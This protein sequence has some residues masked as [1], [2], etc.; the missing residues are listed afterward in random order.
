MRR[1][2]LIWA[3]ILFT[4]A[5]KNKEHLLIEP[6]KGRVISSLDKIPISNVKIYVE[7]NAFNAF[8]TINTKNDGRFFIDQLSVN[9]YKDMHLQ[10][11]LSYNLFIEKDGYKKMVID[12]R[13]YRKQSAPKAGDTTDLGIIYLDKLFVEAE[14]TAT[15]P[16]V[17]KNTSINNKWE[18]T[19]EGSFLRMEEESGDPRAWGRITITIIAIENKVATFHLDTYI[20]NVQKDLKIVHVN[21]KEIQLTDVDG[22]NL[23][24]NLSSDKTKYLLSGNLMEKIVGKKETYTLAKK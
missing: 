21:D 8:D 6:I 23:I 14:K 2:Y 16:I 15:A 10:K 24:L 1:T 13:K 18:G 22:K 3:I 9:G 17:Q 19:Y 4:G 11:N 7:K 12:I 20:E 5:C